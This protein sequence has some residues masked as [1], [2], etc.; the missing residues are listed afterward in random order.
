[1][2]KILLIA[3][4]LTFIKINLLSCIMFTAT[5]EGRTLVG[6]NEDWIDPKTKV[7]FVPPLEGKYGGIYFG[8]SDLVAQGGMNDQGLVFDAMMCPFLEVRKGKGKKQYKGNLMDKLMEEC[9]TVKEAIDLLEQYYIP[10]FA[11]A[12]LMLAD[13]TGAS[14]IIE[15]DIIHYK[16]GKFQVATNF[17]LSQIK[18]D[19]YPCSR[20]KIAMKML[21]KGEVSVDLFKKILHA[22]H[23]KGNL[24]TQYSNIYDLNKGMVYLY[25]SG[26]F[27]NVRMIDFK[28]ELKKGK[29]IL[30]IPALFNKKKHSFNK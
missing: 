22:T 15:G 11:Q 1:M 9:A 25:H 8:F 27:D 12:Q 2:K 5:K 30:D 24:K 10:Q 13:K 16:S 18:G 29:R 17:Y 21:K 7:W 19:N 6:N 20:Y 28:K 3:I 14:A 26:D 4:G 23:M